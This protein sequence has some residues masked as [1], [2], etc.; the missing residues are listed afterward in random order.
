MDNQSLVYELASKYISSFSGRDGDFNY[1]R[2][3]LVA[4]P[5]SSGIPFYKV[6]QIGGAEYYLGCTSKGTLYKRVVRRSYR[7]HMD[8]HEYHKLIHSDNSEDEQKAFDSEEELF[9][10]E[11]IPL[12]YASQIGFIGQKNEVKSYY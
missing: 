1:F 8:V 7:V 11:I 3:H 9:S 6:G 2:D 10:E 5:H 12:M 4:Y